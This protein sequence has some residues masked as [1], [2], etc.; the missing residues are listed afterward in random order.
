MAVKVGASVTKGEYWNM[1]DFAR[2]LAAIT[3]LITIVTA[4][5]TVWQ[6]QRLSDIE[7]AKRREKWE[8]ET[9]DKY[10]EMGVEGDESNPSSIAMSKR[11]R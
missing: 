10:A 1:D 9:M 4:I 2:L 5:L 8:Q 6:Q 11:I 7:R 3:A